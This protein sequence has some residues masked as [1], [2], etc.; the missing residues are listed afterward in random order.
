MRLGVERPQQRAFGDV[1]EVA[2]VD[3]RARR[4][5][6]LGPG[7]RRLR[8]VAIERDEPADEAARRGAVVGR[9]RHREID[10]HLRD[11][12]LARD[13]DNL[14]R[15]DANEADQEHEAEDE[16][17][18]PE[19]LR[20]GEQPFDEVRRPKSERERDEAAETRPGEA[21]EG[22]ARAGDEAR[23]LRRLDLDL[24]FVDRRG[25]AAAGI[26]SCCERMTA[27]GA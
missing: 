27:S 9:A 20:L 3:D 19:R 7:A 5:L 15:R 18:D 12:R 22:Q 10:M 25:A 16:P 14:A 1:D 11:P 13:R 6:D 17:D 23:F 24:R 26:G 2:S 21:G 4:I 8:P